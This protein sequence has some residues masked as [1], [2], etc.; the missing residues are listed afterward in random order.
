[1]QIRA[2]GTFD[3]KMTPQGWAESQPEAAKTLGRFLIDKQIHGDLEATTQGQMLAC[4]D[5]KPSS[6]GAY[7]AIER[8]TGTLHGRSGSFALCHVG[9][10]A[11]GA[12]EL[13]IK[14]VPGSGTDEL[15][16][17]AGEF[18]IKRDEGKH[19]YEFDY[20]LTTEQ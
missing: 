20:T 2:N 8:V 6:S 11:Q 18:R 19:S 16:G 14:V 9:L 10:I 1:M 15:H 3:V 7:V 4:C 12:P 13:T 5:G 17:I